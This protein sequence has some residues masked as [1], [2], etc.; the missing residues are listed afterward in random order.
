MTSTIKPDYC[1]CG[2]YLLSL[3]APHSFTGGTV[4]GPHTEFS[5]VF[6]WCKDCREANNTTRYCANCNP[7]H[8]KV[9]EPELC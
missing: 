9:P 5:C 8:R 2:R 3:R 6:I 1:R 4:D 7:R